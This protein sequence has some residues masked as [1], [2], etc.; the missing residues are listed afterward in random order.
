[1]AED[2]CCLNDIDRQTAMSA[3]DHGT[4]RRHKYGQTCKPATVKR[5]AGAVE[6]VVVNQEIEFVLKEKNH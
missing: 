6:Q 1:M 2:V 4:N 5:I 3:S